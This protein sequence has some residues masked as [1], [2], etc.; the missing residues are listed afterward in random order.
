V[1]TRASETVCVAVYLGFKN[2][3][4]RASENVGSRMFC[5]PYYNNCR[6]MSVLS[7]PVVPNVSLYSASLRFV[8]LK[9]IGILP[10]IIFLR[11]LN[12]G[13]VPN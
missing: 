10:V 7:M 3:L 9:I 8:I 6:L 2:V 12:Y 13:M 11:S 5:T 4:T 1:V